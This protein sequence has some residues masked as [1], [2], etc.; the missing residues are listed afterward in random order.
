MNYIIDFF[1]YLNSRKVSGNIEFEIPDEQITVGSGIDS[2]YLLLT[3]SPSAWR[4]NLCQEIIFLN[5]S[6]HDIK[7]SKKNSKV[8]QYFD[9]K[10]N[11]KL[12]DKTSFK[13]IP[14]T[15]EDIKFLEAL[16]E[17]LMIFNNMSKIISKFK[18]EENLPNKN[19]SIKKIKL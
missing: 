4:S 3:K 1:E 14:I 10:M 17:K 16:E 13:E 18:I 11:D 5:E 2:Y 8:A 19:I 6:Q 12:I 15:S 7:I 9:S